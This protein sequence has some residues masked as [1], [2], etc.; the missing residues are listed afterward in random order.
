MVNK[1]V[2]EP[3]T[4]SISF[5]ADGVSQAEIGSNNQISSDNMYSE[6]INNEV[7]ASEFTGAGLASKVENAISWLDSNTG[8]QGRVI[9]TPKDD[10][11][12]WT[13]DKDLVID[14]IA[15][16][17]IHIQIGHTVNIDYPGSGIALTLDTTWANQNGQ[18]DRFSTI[19]GGRW[20][21]TGT[22]PVGCIRLEDTYKTKVKPSSIGGFQNT[23]G[24]SFGIQLR[25]V[26]GWTES[27]LIEGCYFMDTD[28]MVDLEPANV[29]GGPGTGSFHDTE[30]RSNRF[31]VRNL[32]LRA[33]GAVD[34]STIDSNSFFTKASGAT[35]VQLGGADTAQESHIDGTT[36][37]NN[38]FED[39]AGD[40]TG[41]TA[42]RLAPNFFSFKQPAMINNKMNMKTDGVEVQDDTANT[43]GKLVQ[44]RITD[45]RFIVEDLVQSNRFEYY[46]DRGLGEWEHKVDKVVPSKWMQINPVDLT[47]YPN[48][49][50][51]AGVVAYNDGTVGNEGLAEYR[52]DGNWYHIAS[53]TQI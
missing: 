43:D 37:L 10:G 7:Y 22:D 25:N 5:L 48:W 44:M 9:V 36:L 45:S 31:E 35:H 4:D 16:G 47:T 52:S 33:R 40:T 3:G 12:N 28:I 46:Y 32:G 29:N 6:N 42:I 23:A 41:D 19:E 13:W 24:D 26:D 21:A 11:T 53:N 20:N 15:L 27:T 8:G 50:L 14:P 2:I 30:I 39:P 38:K 18:F 1:W 34:Y 51:N 17:G 49:Q